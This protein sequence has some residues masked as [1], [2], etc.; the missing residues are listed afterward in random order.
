MFESN[1]LSFSKQGVITKKGTE[2]F[3]IKDFVQKADLQSGA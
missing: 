2:A 3:D 1:D